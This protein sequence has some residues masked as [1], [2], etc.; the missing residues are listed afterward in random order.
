MQ[1][2]FRLEESS[3]SCSVGSITFAHFRSANI[4][5]AKA[6]PTYHHYLPSQKVWLQDRSSIHPPVMRVGSEGGG[7]GRRCSIHREE[8]VVNITFVLLGKVIPE[9]GFLNC[10][11]ELTS[12]FIQNYPKHYSLPQSR[13][14]PPFYH[15]RK[16]RR[17]KWI[18]F[19]LSTCM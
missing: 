1:G 5:F 16:R 9:K 18:L 4:S 12:S 15:P 6:A 3:A 8:S 7:S 19:P 17:I 11:I 13:R 14:S 2:E 10:F